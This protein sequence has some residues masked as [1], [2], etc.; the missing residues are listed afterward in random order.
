LDHDIVLDFSCII[1][2]LCSLA[3]LFL[4]DNNTNIMV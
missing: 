2:L 4:K 1:S 3:L